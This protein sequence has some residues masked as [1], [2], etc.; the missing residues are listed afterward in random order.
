MYRVINFFT[1]L[2][3]KDH[4]Y[5]VGD[6]FPREG[7]KTSEERLAEL[8]GG[9]NKQ[10]KPLIEKVDGEDDLNSKSVKELKAMLN[11]MKIEYR[12]NASKA[13]LIEL[14]EKV[15]GEDDQDKDE[16]PEE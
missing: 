16:A 5:N 14:I 1:D 7:I 9:N 13:D 12:G 15:D 3:D 11:E 2:H 6:T 8:A 10:H 4:E